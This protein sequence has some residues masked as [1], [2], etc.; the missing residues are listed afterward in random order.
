MRIYDTVR[1]DLPVFRRARERRAGLPSL[2][3]AQQE[4]FMTPTVPAE[5]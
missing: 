4:T 1:K 2:I 3:A 5:S